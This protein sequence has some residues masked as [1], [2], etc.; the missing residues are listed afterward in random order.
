MTASK[1]L[2]I[3]NGGR[4]HAMCR[5]IA[6]MPDTEVLAAPGNP[7]TER[8]ARNVDVAASD[9][10]ALVALA[11]DEKVDLVVPGPEAVLV[12]GIAD[13][14]GEAGIPC[15]G[16]SAGAAML[17]G[18]KAFMRELTEA[19]GVPGTRFVTV[20][21]AASLAG[22]VAS[23]DGVP[24]VK[25]DGLAA[26]KGVYL[27]DTKDG[28]VEIGRELLDG[29]HGDAGRVIV[30]EE[31]LVG[32]E[33][34]LF[35]ACDGAQAL[36]LPHARDHKR[37]HDQDQGPNTGGMGA[38][39]PNPSIDTRTEARV[40][41]EVIEPTLAALTERGTPFRGFLYAGLM[42]TETGPRLLE[43]NVRLGDPEAQVILPRLPPGGFADICRSAARGNIA[44][45]GYDEDPRTT[46][47]VVLAAEGYP[48][49]PRQ[50]DPISL[51]AGF[52]TPDRWLDHAGTAC[53]DGVLVTSGGR[54]AAVVARAEDA[55][56]AR[57]LANEGVGL[58]RFRGK[59]VRTDIGA[60][61]GGQ[62]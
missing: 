47:C 30:L 5:A 57:R 54:V 15:C 62:S 10:A 31:R 22:A 14:L 58:V 37:L 56:S 41:R 40:R 23:W 55:E 35:Y 7:G 29:K 53:H 1:V 2:V 17:E 36:A 38:V 11:K 59:H 16:P 46:C 9:L 4:E 33:A 48:E 19:A 25:A 27:P 28:A 49:S 45:L 26:G 3:G 24:V 20:D 18:S 8:C 61:P 60:P 34:S 12:A 21:N 39:S 32:T 6:T 51:H 13:A 52:D 50:G 42:L 44:R 43:F